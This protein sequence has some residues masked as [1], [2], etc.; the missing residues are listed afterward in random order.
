[1]ANSES[2]ATPL[3]PTTPPDPMNLSPWREYALGYLRAQ[4]REDAPG[5]LG[6][7]RVFERSPLEGD[8]A[9]VVFEFRARR[10]AAESDQ[11]YVVV[12]QTEPNYYPAYG[13]DADEAYSLHLGTRFMLVMGVAQCVAPEGI[14]VMAAA[15]VVV[16]RVAPSA[17]I[18][19]LTVAACFDVEGQHHVVLRGRVAGQDVYIMAGEAPAGFS[20]RVELPPQVAYRLHVGAVLR[21]EAHRAE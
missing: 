4:L 16:D 7:A 1:M 15:R 13:L 6:V 5:E 9:V 18:E 3:N 10:G 20:R 19:G 17:P 12:G 21:V 8:G 14:D 2:E 11:Y